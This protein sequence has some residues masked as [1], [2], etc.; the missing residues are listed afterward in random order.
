MSN[1]DPDRTEVLYWLKG[2]DIL[3]FGDFLSQFIADEA[4]LTPRVSAPVYRLVG[5]VIDEGIIDEDLRDKAEGSKIAFWCCGARDEKGLSEQALQRCLFFGVRGPLTRD[6]LHLPIN[7]PIGDPGLLLP[8]LYSP[9]RSARTAGKT[10]CVPHFC[11]PKSDAELLASSGAQL[12]VRPQVS[13]T[14]ELL[15]L[16][17]ELVSAQFILAGSL[18]AAI[19]ACA[20]DV[21]FGF[22]DN[23]HVDLPFK[24]RDFGASINITPCFTDSIKDGNQLYRALLKT[25]LRKP[26]LFPVLEIAP[27][28]VKADILK[29]AAVRDSSE[30]KR[31]QRSSLWRGTQKFSDQLIRR[32]LPIRQKPGAAGCQAEAAKPPRWRPDV[33]DGAKWILM[34]ESRIPM[35]EVNGASVRLFHIIKILVSR[36]SKIFFISDHPHSAYHWVLNDIK[37][38]AAHEQKLRQLGVQVVYGRELAFQH[39]RKYGA[40]YDHAFLF[41][42]DVAFAYAPIVK[43][44]CPNATIVFD[45]VD[46][47][48]V[49]LERE[50]QIKRDSRIRAEADQYRRKETYLFDE[51]DVTTAISEDE[52]EV[53]RAMNPETH[54]ELL[55][56]IFDEQTPSLPY[57]SRGGLIFIGHY[58]HS[59][60]VDAVRYFVEE[61]FPLIRSDIPDVKFK[62]IGSNPTEDIRKISAPGVQFVGFLEDLDATF[63]HARVFVAPLRYGAGVKGKI[64]QSMSYGLPVVT[65][66]I[67]AEG[68][69]LVHGTTALIADNPGTFAQEV[70][71]L[72]RDR[73]LWEKLSINSR[74]AIQ[75]QMSVK[76][77]AEAIDRILGVRRKRRMG[78]D[79]KYTCD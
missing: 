42:P 77:A 31:L 4:F 21:P 26:P 53:I 24:W 36:G 49:R 66:T 17:D 23:G 6:L 43:T 16:L 28:S 38:I 51:C 37:E 8:L 67:G 19:V 76:N 69:R 47:H 33:N 5:S 32:A 79:W 60:N 78:L 74:T 61:I 48:S 45:P 46:L 29:S 57:D 75:K 11:D 44:Y 58:L 68:M 50:S 62:I 59:P 14:E 22:W 12:V 54:I 55:R 20:Y 70:A 13:N 65:T 40:R 63:A 35:P 9:R 15:S 39:L 27:F 72:Y 52:A 25:R 3:N 71:R 73:A 18:H 34:A 1:S 2:S 56:N 7:T 30:Q 10:I 64:G 41:Y